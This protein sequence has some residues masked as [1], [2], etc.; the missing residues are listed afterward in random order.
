MILGLIPT[1]TETLYFARRKAGAV[2][3]SGATEGGALAPAGKEEQA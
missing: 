2:P 1:A 3:A